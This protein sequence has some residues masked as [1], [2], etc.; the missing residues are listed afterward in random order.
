MLLLPPPHSYICGVVAFGRGVCFRSQVCLKVVTVSPRRPSEVVLHW[1]FATKCFKNPRFTV[2]LMLIWGLVWPRIYS[3]AHTRLRTCAS[4][5]RSFCGNVFWKHQCTE[6]RSLAT[7][8]EMFLLN[9]YY[10]N[11]SPTF[12]MSRENDPDS[13]QDVCP[14]RWRRNGDRWEY[15]WNIWG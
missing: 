10:L 12:E 2:K 1:V 3:Q 6:S 13:R 15:L 9:K 14:L 11:S 5:K 8:N 4:H 7:L